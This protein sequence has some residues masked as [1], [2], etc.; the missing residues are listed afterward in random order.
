LSSLRIF[1]KGKRNKIEATG[2][3]LEAT[4]VSLQEK[5]VCVEVRICQAS[6][7]NYVRHAHAPLIFK[8]TCPTTEMWYYH[9]NDCCRYHGALSRDLRLSIRLHASKFDDVEEPIALFRSILL[10]VVEVA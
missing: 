4:H 10:N 7:L 3:R 9:H 8:Q 2:F 5:W 6:Y 1:I